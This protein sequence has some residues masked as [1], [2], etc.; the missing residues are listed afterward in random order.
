MNLI[1]PYV[2]LLFLLVLPGL[3]VAE[4]NDSPYF[5]LKRMANAAHTL[6]YEGTFVYLEHGRLQSLKVTHGVDS[7]GE[8]ERVITLNG[9][10]REINIKN[11]KLVYNFPNQ[12]SLVPK[13]SGAGFSF[14][15]LDQAKL[16]RL[17]GF[18]DFTLQG[19]DRVA[20][21][22]TRKL[23]VIPKD[24]YRY[25]YN[26]WLA[27]DNGLLLRSEMNIEQGNPVEQFIFTSI[28]LSDRFHNNQIKK[29]ATTKENKKYHLSW[30]STHADN[31]YKWSVRKLPPGFVL[32]MHRR[33]DM[34]VSN[35]P[36][37]H[38]VFAD[39]LAS[40]SVYIE[41]DN[42]NKDKPNQ[43]SKMGGVSFVSKIVDG[44]RIVVVGEVPLAT[45]EY[46]AESVQKSRS[47][48]D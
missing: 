43:T 25:G 19:K 5:W 28:T 6:N 37:E 12:E 26:I 45:V 29:P 39:G 16:K 8:W 31:L 4:T 3:V 7:L 15:I 44:H 36:V 34:A 23:S 13:G 46:I 40:V 41:S 18:Y 20:G 35:R 42:A 9:A 48:N 30:H 27:E 22:A 24:K 17:A 10:F 2:S 32:T 1:T 14:P 21:L 38:M 33:H 47:L 11:G